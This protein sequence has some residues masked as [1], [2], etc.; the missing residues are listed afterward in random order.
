MSI[1]SN[2]MIPISTTLGD[3]F[4][5]S[6]LTEI[7]QQRLVRGLSLDS[8]TVK[9]GDVFFAYPGVIADGR[10]YIQAAVEKGAVAVIVESDESQVFDCSDLNV[11]V[12]MVEDLRH[13]VGE[14]AALFWGVPSS[15]LVV[16]AVTGTNG[17]T[18]VTQMIAE[19]ID[20][21]GNKGAVIGTLGNGVLG[22]LKETKNTTP[23]ALQIQKLLSGF[24]RENI[25][26]VAM[27]ASS[28]GLA[29][30]RLL[31][32]RID[33]AV[34]TNITRDHLDYHGSMEAYRRAKADL[35]MWPGI[36][37]VILNADDIDVM[38]LTGYIADDVE[39]VTFS[40][41]SS[42][43]D[44]RAEDIAYSKR[45][46]E[47]TLAISEDR[48]NVKNQ[49]VG[50][51]NVS[52]L[53]T[54]A[55]V[56]HCQ[57]YDIKQIALALNSISQVPGRMQ[58][59]GLSS[60]ELNSKSQGDEL[61]GVIVD[62]AHTPDALEKALTALKPHC[63]GKLWCVFGCGG[64]RDKGKRSEMGA[65]AAKYADRMVIT[66]DNPRNE[67]ASEIVKEIEDGIGM[68]A[69]YQVE[70]DR[71]EAVRCAVMNAANDDLILLAGKGHENYQD[72]NGKKHPYSDKSVAEKV[73]YERL[74]CSVAGGG[75]C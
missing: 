39:V 3:L 65:M 21:M 70:L 13:A 46:L 74:Q 51:F 25:D 16:V 44:V 2:K 55:T 50:E 19:S 34:V 45:G 27:E 67:S 24:V 43:A 29:Q 60:T 4:S 37:Q 59:V 62:F 53:L 32:T 66:A 6:T 7:D 71:E 38:A 11:P 35:V 14:I 36:R 1:G 26:V 18:S 10:Q 20:S 52:N 49:L 9:K 28:H 72:I 22:Q 58:E 64:E 75:Q 31:G 40:H 33:I 17:K 61:P 73:L 69:A 63:E 47:F 56:L 8:R 54:V 15:Q 12:L 68:G 48:E 41:V 57:Q 5:N 30:G 42:T 23:D